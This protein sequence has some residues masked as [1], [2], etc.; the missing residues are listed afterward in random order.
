MS[1]RHLSEDRLIALSL[2]DTAPAS[3]HEEH[4]A[5]C[6]SCRAR[7]ASLSAMLD[8]VA[9]A[10]AIEADAAF[11]PDRLVRQHTRILQRLSADGRPGRV[12]AFPA[13]TS[14]AYDAMSWRPATRW[15]A[16]AALAGLFVG[17]LA[18]QVLTHLPTG[19]RGNGQPAS[20]PAMLASQPV[21]QPVVTSVSDDE[22]LGQ[23]EAAVQGGGPVMLRPLDAMTPL[24][25]DVSR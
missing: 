10:S 4:L 22:F 16:A 11:P 18:D 8:E 12:I 2:G 3:G 23:L 14:G 1:G 19:T 21:I 20:A 15:I 6:D 9:A 5:V 17:V 13:G 25:W 24:A 7:C